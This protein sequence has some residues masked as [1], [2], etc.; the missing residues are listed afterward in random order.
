MKKFV[1][2]FLVLCVGL[3]AMAQSE[4]KTILKDGR[5][6][7]VRYVYNDG[8]RWYVDTVKYTITGE[9]QL[10][11]KTWKMIERSDWQEETMYAREEG[12]K[13]YTLLAEQYEQL[14][15]DMNLKTG[16]TLYENYVAVADTIQVN[17]TDYKR[18]RQQDSYSG[19]IFDSAW[20]EGIGQSEYRFVMYPLITTWEYYHMLAC[21]DNDVCIFEMKDFGVSDTEVEEILT[22]I[23]STYLDK[24][25]ISDRI[26]DLNGNIVT[27]PTPRSIYIQN[28]KKFI[29]K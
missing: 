12:G 10:V 19:R 7:K 6:W 18:I 5:S 25:A 8:V 28:G 14:M 29:A 3:A 16:D 17:G 27:T 1:S 21:Y 24:V 20:V 23:H 11:G 26:Y 22:G 9:K 13:M 15:L 2:L 4:F